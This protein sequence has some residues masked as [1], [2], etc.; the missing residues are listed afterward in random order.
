[1]AALRKDLDEYMADDP[2]AD[3]TTMLLVRRTS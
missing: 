3:D 2:L 1:M